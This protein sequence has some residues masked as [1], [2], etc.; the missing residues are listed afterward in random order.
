V[1]PPAPKPVLT[2]SGIVWGEEPAA[3]IE[4]LPG[5]ERARVLHRGDQVA[6]VTLRTITPDQVILVGMDTSW[7]LRVRQP[8]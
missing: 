3:V 6:G 1:A 5:L 2:L 7:A 8:W 4:G